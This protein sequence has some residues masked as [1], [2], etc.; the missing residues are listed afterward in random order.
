MKKYICV[1]DTDIGDDIDD[2]FALALLLENPEIELKAVTTV[3]KNTKLR[4]HQ[5]K[6]LLKTY[7]SDVDVYYGEGMPLT[8][9][10]VPF[11]TEHVHET[12][13]LINNHPCQYDSS[14]TDEV[15]ENAVD[16]ILK[17]TD[18][19]I[20]LFGVTGSGKT[21]VYMHVIEKILSENKIH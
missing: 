18:K 16:K 10:I 3:Y 1:L 2:A 7:G 11:R 20:V 15:K 5:A 19:P 21:E 4:A 9:Y 8:G 13:D 12:G 17:S 6:Q 14:M